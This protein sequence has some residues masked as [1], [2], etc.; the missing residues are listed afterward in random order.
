MKVAFVTHYDLHNKWRWS[1]HLIGHFGTSYYM[2]QSLKKHCDLEFIGPLADNYS[3]V[4]K[5]EYHT[6]RLLNIKTYHAWAAPSININYA[7]QIAKNILII[8]PDIILCPHMNVIAYLQCK[9]P[10]VLWTD[11]LYAGTMSTFPDGEPCQTSI[12]H[13]KTLDKLALKNCKL[14]IFS[15]D[16]A[17]QL[18]I[19]TYKEAESA[20]L[21]RFTEGTASRKLSAKIKVVPTGANLECNRTKNEIENIIKSK[22]S[23][24]CKL[25]FCGVNWQR[26]GGDVALEVAKQLNNSGLLTELTILGCQPL[27][28]ESLPDFVKVYGFVDRSIQEGQKLVESLFTENH[29]LVLPSK[30]DFTPGVLREASSFGLPCISTNIGGIPTLIRDGYNGKTFEADASISEYCGYITDLFA[31]YSK[32]IAL[33]LSSFQE[34]QSRL[35]WNAAGEATMRHLQSIL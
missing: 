14:I 10:I 30:V 21:E 27:A 4:S 17:A 15:S 33:S 6:H 23:K 3:L 19:Q 7:Q 26:K 1:P 31:N 28:D 13:L 16:W 24:V 12:R 8:K 18:A 9:Q 35:N 32:Y 11:S 5:V 20:F 25:L 22:S 2:A 29:F 34:Y